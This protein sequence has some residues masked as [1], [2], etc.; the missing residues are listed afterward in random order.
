MNAAER[1]S[2]YTAGFRKGRELQR[3]ESALLFKRMEHEAQQGAERAVEIER[4]RAALVRLYTAAKVEVAQASS[5]SLYKFHEALG[6]VGQM[7][8]T[9]R[10]EDP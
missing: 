10:E 3:R 4:L 1:E 7:I 8:Q 9:T 5:P 2:I 6:E